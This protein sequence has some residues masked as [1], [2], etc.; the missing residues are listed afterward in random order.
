MRRKIEILNDLHEMMLNGELKSTMIEFKGSPKNTKYN[1][2][3]WVGW[4]KDEPK[5]K[6]IGVEYKWV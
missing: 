2:I 3:Y 1:R 6:H 4:T 5:T